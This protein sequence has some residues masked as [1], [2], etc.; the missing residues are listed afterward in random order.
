[1]MWNHYDIYYGPMGPFI[2]T[3]GLVLY[4]LPSFIAFYRRHH[5]RYA[6]FMLNLLLGWSGLG[7]IIA[8]IWSLTMVQKQQS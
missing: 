4:F 8:L 2:S 1:M 7:W 5:N 6:I 3:L